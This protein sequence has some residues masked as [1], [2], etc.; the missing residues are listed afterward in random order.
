M[1]PRQKLKKCRTTWR[2]GVRRFDRA[3]LGAILVTT[4][5]RTAS[6]PDAP[7]DRPDVRQQRRE[8]VR[9]QRIQRLGLICFVGKVAHELQRRRVLRLREDRRRD[10]AASPPGHARTPSRPRP[11]AAA[12][13]DSCRGQSARSGRTCR[14][15]PTVR[16]IEQRREERL[17][18]EPPH[19]SQVLS[20]HQP[21]VG[22]TD[23][24]G[25][26][27]CAG[28]QL[29]RKPGRKPGEIASLRSSSFSISRS[30]SVTSPSR[31]SAEPR[32]A[33]S[34]PSARAQ[35]RDP[36]RACV[37]DRPLQGGLEE[38][39]RQRIQHPHSDGDRESNPSRTSSAAVTSG[40][41]RTV[42]SRRSHSREA[43]PWTTAWQQRARRPSGF[44]EG[45]ARFRPTPPNGRSCEGFRSASRNAAGHNNS[46]TDGAMPRREVQ[47]SVL[48]EQ[49]G[50]G[51]EHGYKLRQRR[52][53]GASATSTRTRSRPDLIALRAAQRFGTD[54][55]AQQGRELHDGVD[56]AQRPPR[57]RM[58]R[59]SR[60][61]R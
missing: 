13:R 22:V 54:R 20:G 41:G 57:H 60:V 7:R 40:G 58:P 23:R 48:A 26:G 38:M 19:G 31:S 47:A 27:L 55:L 43:A 49:R 42:P 2:A 51:V 4:G 29:L 5:R 53:Y 3:S 50:A 56:H 45:A 11:R 46:G 32:R 10:R 24:L 8:H 21:T 6:S 18:F 39:R 30:A 37:A 35:A 16:E 36:T 44:R 52:T 28:P 59:S 1:A 25:D 61:P 12:P 33:A 17:P 15:R 34:E 9:Q 14:T